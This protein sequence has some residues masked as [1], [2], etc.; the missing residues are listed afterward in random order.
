ME[1]IQNNSKYDW[2]GGGEGAITSVP[3]VPMYWYIN[4]SMRYM[5]NKIIQIVHFWMGLAGVLP[6]ADWDHLASI[7]IILPISIYL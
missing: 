4:I 7:S 6:H 3:G 2:G 5:Y 1:V